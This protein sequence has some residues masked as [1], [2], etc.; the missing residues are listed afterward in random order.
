MRWQVLV[1]GWPGASVCLLLTVVGLFLRRHVLV[2]IATSFGV[3]F[4]VYLLKAMPPL[5]ALLLASQ[6]GCILALR[7]NRP[8]LAYFAALPTVALMAVPVA[9]ALR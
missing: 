3:G 2:A 8:L 5:G 6:L 7:A 9:L 1:F 4:C